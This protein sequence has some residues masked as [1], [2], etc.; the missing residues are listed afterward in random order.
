RFATLVREA[1]DAAHAA[2]SKVPIVSGGLARFDG[3]DSTGYDS[4][5]FLATAYANGM[6]HHLD[7][8]GLHPYP[9][10]PDDGRFFE[11]LTEAREIRDH[12]G[13]GAIPLWIT[14]FGVSTSA[15]GDTELH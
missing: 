7:G 13:D 11:M 9:G 14:E 5:Q 2:G 10:S 1:D 8:I 6:A 4:R 3:I 15:G 12:A